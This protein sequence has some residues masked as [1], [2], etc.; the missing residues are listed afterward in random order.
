MG[1]Y[2]LC[3]KI[4]SQRLVVSGKKPSIQDVPK[5]H[6]HAS[7]MRCK[8]NLDAQNME[9]TLSFLLLLLA[10][11]RKGALNLARSFATLMIHCSGAKDNVN[12]AHTHCV[13]ILPTKSEKRMRSDMRPRRLYV[14]KRL[15]CNLRLEKASD[16]QAIEKHDGEPYWMRKILQP[17]LR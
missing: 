4:A 17:V 13:P 14:R 10:A 8:A 1:D 5:K 16:V 15:S 2:L 7:K 9:K 6:Q 11:T 3:S 12:C